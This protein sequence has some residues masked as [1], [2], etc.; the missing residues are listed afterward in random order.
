MA[1]SET[2]YFRAMSQYEYRKWEEQGSI[3]AHMEWAVQKLW[4]GFSLSELKE[5]VD[6]PQKSHDLVIAVN[7]SSPLE[8]TLASTND[9]WDA[10]VPEGNEDMLPR[11]YINRG[12]ILF[13]RAQIVY[14]PKAIVSSE[15]ILDLEQ[16]L[17]PQ[18]FF[19]RLFYIF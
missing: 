11:R 6:D 1:E 4:N 17:K 13:S 14:D 7:G 8:F 15:S 19:K 2:R 5:W 16:I 12:P 3:A 10:D 9:R 18:P